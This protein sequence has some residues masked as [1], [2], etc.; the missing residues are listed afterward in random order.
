MAG[1]EG[2]PLAVVRVRVE[3]AM[4]R[5]V[6]RSAVLAQAPGDAEE[7]FDRAVDRVVIGAVADTFSSDGV[8][9]VSE[10]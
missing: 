7:G 5:G 6:R 1:L 2:V 4:E 10:F 8:L 3:V 9:L